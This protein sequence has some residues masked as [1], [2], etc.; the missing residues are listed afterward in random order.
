MS[1]IDVREATTKTHREKWA[2]IVTLVDQLVRLDPCPIIVLNR[3]IAA[4]A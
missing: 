3:A 1:G 4:R 2:Q